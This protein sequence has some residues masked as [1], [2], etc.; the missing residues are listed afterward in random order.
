M[1]PQVPAQVPGLVASPSPNVVLPMYKPS[2]EALP[3]TKPKPEPPVPGP[4]V[5]GPARSGKPET[6]PQVTLISTAAFRQESKLEGAQVF[7]VEI[8]PETMGHSVT[9]N[10]TPVNL[11]GVPEAYHDYADVFSKTKASILADHRPYDLKVTLE[12]GTALPLGPIYSLSQEELL[13]L[14]KF[15]DENVATGFIR[16]S[17]SPHGAPVLFIRKKDGSLHLCIDFQGI[18]KISKKDR[19][20]LPLIS[21]LLDAPCKAHIYTKIDLWHAYHLV[22]ITAGDEWK[23]VFRTHYSSFEWLVMPEGL[24]NAPAGFQRFMNDIFADMINVSMVVYLDNILIYSDNPDQHTAH[25]QEVLSHLHKNRLYARADKCE[26]HTNSC[27]YL[28]YMLSPQGLTMSAYK[29]QA[30]QDWP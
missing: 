17:W 6:T 1:N 2:V 16:P 28:G 13:A 30:I 25:V 7:Q 23:T 24:T 15:I 4:A 5:P 9:T 21:D 10:P 19:Y 14:H 18:N 29:I 22:H 12:E 20:P 3:S 26:F 11:D 27:E 8:S